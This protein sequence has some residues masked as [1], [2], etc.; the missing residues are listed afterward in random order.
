[1][2]TMIE[3]VDAAI[4]LGQWLHHMREAL[5]APSTIFWFVVSLVL[6]MILGPFSAPIAL[7]TIFGQGAE[8]R[9]C[10]EPESVG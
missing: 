10:S 4:P 9:G 2:M 6:F 5:P 3:F 7:L 8:G 1:M